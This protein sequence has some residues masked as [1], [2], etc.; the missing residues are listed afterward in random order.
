MLVLVVVVVVV[1]VVVIKG[2][3]KVRIKIMW[4]ESRGGRER[5][6]NKQRMEEG[7][8]KFSPKIVSWKREGSPFAL[9][10]MVWK[11]KEKGKRRKGGKVV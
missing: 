10:S 8:E 4:K 9:N 6:E 5:R 3:R 11:E 1:M 2:E 7:E